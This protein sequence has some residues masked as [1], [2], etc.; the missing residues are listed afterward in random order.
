MGNSDKSRYAESFTYKVS[1]KPNWQ[2]NGRSI[3]SVNTASTKLGVKQINLTFM[4]NNN[5]YITHFLVQQ[6]IPL[7]S[8]ESMEYIIENLVDVMNRISFFWL[9]PRN[10]SYKTNDVSIL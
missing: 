2:K 5:A 1:F 8:L 7:I 10:M 3:S 9:D 4:L 6:H